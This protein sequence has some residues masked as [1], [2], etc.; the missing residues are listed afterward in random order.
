MSLDGSYDDA[1]VFAKI[2]RGEIPSAPVFEDDEVL[3]F[4]DAFPQAKGHCLVI[5]KVSRAR[6]LLDVEPETLGA[7]AAATQRLARAVRK[8]LKPDGIVVTQFNGA[9]AGQTVF[10]LHFHVIP[11]FEGAPLDRHGGGMAD[12]AELKALAAQIAAA[13]D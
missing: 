9:P 3:A 8:A 13:L 2:I 1:N 6:N 12:P 4:M 7:L 11:R 5:S 10:H